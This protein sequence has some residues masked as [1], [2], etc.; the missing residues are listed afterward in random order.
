PI[1]VNVSDPDVTL[2]C[3]GGNPAAVNVPPQDSVECTWSDAIGG[4]SVPTDYSNTVTVSGLW[5][6]PAINGS[7]GTIVFTIDDGSDTT[8][9]DDNLV[10]DVIGGTIPDGHVIN[11]DQEFEYTVTHTCEGITNWSQLDGSGSKT[12]E[13]TAT[14]SDTVGNN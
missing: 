5:D 4:D 7:T 10:G 12:V 3:P 2:V 13:N 6:G 14:I 9:V 8:T 11:D 1:E